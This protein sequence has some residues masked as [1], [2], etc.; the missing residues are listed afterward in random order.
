MQRAGGA[1]SGNGELEMDVGSGTSHV[2]SLWG[3]GKVRKNSNP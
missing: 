1:D 2:I 3:A